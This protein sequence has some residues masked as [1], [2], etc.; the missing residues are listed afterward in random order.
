MKCLCT[1]ALLFLVVPAC[2]Q[3]GDLTKP[4]MV[5]VVLDHPL[6]GDDT[7]LRFEVRDPRGQLLDKHF[8]HDTTRDSALLFSLPPSASPGLWQIADRWSGRVMQLNLRPYESLLHTTITLPF[9]QGAYNVDITRLWKCLTDQASELP[10]NDKPW[11]VRTDTLACGGGRVVWARAHGSSE[12]RF[13]DLLPFTYRVQQPPLVSPREVTYPGGM[14]NFQR[15]IRTHFSRPLIERTG[16]RAKLSALVNIETDGSIHKVHLNGSAYPELDREFKRVLQLSS[17]WE[18]AVV[19]NIHNTIDPRSFRYIEQSKII[20]YTVDPDS[21]WIE[22]PEEA[23]SISPREPTSRDSL[24]IT[25]LWMDGSCGQYAGDAELLTSVPGE[26]VRTIILRFGATRPNMCE[27]LKALSWTHVM[28][29]LPPGRY[30]LKREDMPG[31]APAA[32]AA[33]PYAVRE[34][35]VR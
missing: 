18:P 6:Y 35:E 31:I 3:P 13:F 26:D 33:D 27:D 2:G 32:W 5:N 23:L 34:F 25:L 17:W 11:P 30:R 29:P 20:E 21:I 9:T 12:I 8:I 19:E 4:Y 1:S 24:Y 15:F 10:G 22:I 14:A 16:V 7:T 28:P